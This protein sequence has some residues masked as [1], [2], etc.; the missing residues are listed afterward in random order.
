MLIT[1]WPK[2]LLHF[3]GSG[4]RTGLL[5]VHLNVVCIIMDCGAAGMVSAALLSERV[6]LL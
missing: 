2:Q 1:D 3:R 6:G 5:T 4:V